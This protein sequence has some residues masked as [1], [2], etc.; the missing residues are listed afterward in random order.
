MEIVPYWFQNPKIWFN[1]SD[2]EDQ[3]IKES[4]EYLL[5]TGATSFLG[6]ILLYDQIVRHVYRKECAAHII[7]FFLNK[8]LLYSC[9]LR[10]TEIKNDSHWVFANMPF[11]HAKIYIPNLIKETWLRICEL[12]S[13]R[14]I[15]K[16][17]LNSCYMKSLDP[18][19]NTRFY[20][21]FSF[22]AN[23]SVF[24]LQKYSSILQHLPK[25]PHCKNNKKIIK[26]PLYQQIE[27]HLK[28]I[29]DITISLSGGVDSMVTL[30]LVHQL[31]LHHPNIKINAFHMNYLNR[32]NDN[33]LEESF[34]RKWCEYY[35]IDL[36]I[37][38]IVHQKM[39]PTRLQEFQKHH[40]RTQSR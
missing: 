14:P 40:S 18:A 16:R 32:Q 9:F 7:S 12:E 26:C 37:K 4:F 35:E 38:R 23:G 30:H 27:L 34:I 19:I 17:F 1:C 28:G 25:H 15:L 36:T 20:Q 31:K 21:G 39:P 3:Y 24:S 5:D 8:A 10:Q 33:I 11:R 2:K 6:N 29:E 22:L 13:D